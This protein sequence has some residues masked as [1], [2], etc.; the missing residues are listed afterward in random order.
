MENQKT[1]NQKPK[2]PNWIKLVGNI[3]KGVKSEGD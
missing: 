1:E 2:I 3:I